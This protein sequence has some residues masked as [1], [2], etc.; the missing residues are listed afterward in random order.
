MSAL[1]KVFIVLLVVLSILMTAA[2]VV[3]VSRVENSAQA[4][5]DAKAEASRQSTRANQAEAAAA[6]AKAAEQQVRQAS[7]SQV[8][9]VQGK[10]TAAEQAASAKDVQI[11]ELTSKAAM[12]A[13]DFTRLT[14]GLKSSEDTKSKLQDM[15]VELRKGN[16]DLSKKSGDLNLTVTDLTNKLDVTERE[17]RNLAEQLQE[18]KGQAEKLSSKLKDTGVNVD[19]P[20]PAGSRAGA[21]AINGVIRDVRPIAGIPYATISV[22]SADNVQKGMEFKIVD[23]NTGDYLGDLIVDTVEPNEAVGRLSGKRIAE[24]KAGNEVRTQL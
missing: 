10:L 2:T 14:E 4:A 17:R 11:A 12:Q 7:N 3:F 9:Q 23:R 19:E 16:D 21:V 6:A 20:P 18:T 5:A 8:A 13:A 22:G 1:T 24:V 15:L